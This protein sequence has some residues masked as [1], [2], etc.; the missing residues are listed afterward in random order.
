MNPFMAIHKQPLSTMPSVRQLRAF[1]AVFHTGSISAAAQELALTQ[2]AVTV[3]VR[4][5]EARLGLALFDRSTRAIRRT[6]AAVR[7][8][9]YAQRAL[10]EMEGLSRSMS[11]LAGLHAGRVRVV[12]TAAV[13]QVVLP[14]AM[15][16]FLDRHPGVSL[17][18]EEVAPGDFVAALQASDVDFGVGTLEAP[19]P[20]LQD[21]VLIREPLVAAALP[22]A[23]FPGG[24]PMTWKQLGALPLVMVRSGYG[25]R[26][27]I[28]AAARDAGVTLQVAHEVSLLSTAVA[29]AAN[30]LGVVVVPPSIVAQEARLVTQ[31][32]MRPTVERMIGIQSHRAR[33]LSPTAKAFVQVLRHVA[34]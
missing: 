32:L 25:I 12:A 5:L 18:I 19:V 7:A 3:L 16:R 28:E 29:L 15:R 33:S 31:R 34:L 14:P 21:D 30:G 27:R 13:A 20:G 6:D 23:Q 2:P 8:I 1:V 11:E 4:E 24:V 10:A 22:S 9:G 26:S 17:E